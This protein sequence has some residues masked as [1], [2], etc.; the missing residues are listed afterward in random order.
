MKKNKNTKVSES[1]KNIV[2]ELKKMSYSELYLI[3]NVIHDL[4]GSFQNEE[5]KER[6]KR[7]QEKWE[8]VKE[9]TLQVKAL[10]K[11]K[12]TL[13]FLPKPKNDIP[14][15]YVEIKDRCAYFLDEER[16]DLI[17]FD[18]INGENLDVTMKKLAKW[19]DNIKIYTLLDRVKC[20]RKA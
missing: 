15:K 10:L 19:F 1:V 4:K 18:G 11:E 3:G 13:I 7:Y 2:A 17:I 16:E 20:E 14:L 12:D 5:E 9:K 8:F 6:I